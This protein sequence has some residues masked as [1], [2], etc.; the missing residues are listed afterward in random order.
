LPAKADALYLKTRESVDPL[1]VIDLP[2][3]ERDPWSRLLEKIVSLDFKASL[4]DRLKFFSKAILFVEG[5]TEEKVFPVWAKTLGFDFEQQGIG[6]IGLIGASKANFHLRLWGEIINSVKTLTNKKHL[7]IYMVLDLN[8]KSHGEEAISQGL[9]SQSNCFILSL[10][11]I[12]DYY[13]INA[14]AKAL[15]EMCG[16]KPLREDLRGGRVHAIDHFLRKNCYY[17]DWKIPLG[18]K[19]ANLTLA[20]Q[21]PLEIQNIIKTI[22]QS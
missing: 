2:V 9:V 3:E 12:E 21:I 20:A 16:K 4:Q 11:D 13:P 10:G 15:E 17:K 5:L 7:P 6:I 8:A 1:S 18:I 22:V 19:V 14:L